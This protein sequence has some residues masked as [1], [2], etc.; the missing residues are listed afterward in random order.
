M[1]SSANRA[2]FV[3][4]WLLTPFGSILTFGNGRN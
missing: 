3:R 2:E 1:D 4:V